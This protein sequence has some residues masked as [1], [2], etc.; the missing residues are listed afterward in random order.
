[1]LEVEFLSQTKNSW[2]EFLS[3]DMNLERKSH[4]GKTTITNER[5][6]SRFTPRLS[7]TSAYGLNSS[8]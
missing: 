8:I 7:P 6:R 5:E 2:D 4:S 3:T 1:M